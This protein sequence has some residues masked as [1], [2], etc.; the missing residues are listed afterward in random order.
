MFAVF[1][2]GSDA[3]RTSLLPVDPKR[4]TEPTQ[5]MKLEEE[6]LLFEPS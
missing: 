3:R 1:L 4:I 2:N 6:P 5:S